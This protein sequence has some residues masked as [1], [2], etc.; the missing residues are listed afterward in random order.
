VADWTMLLD[1]QIAD[2]AGEN[3]SNS[4]GTTI[5]AGA[6]ANTKGSYTQLIASTPFDADWIEV[7]ITWGSVPT[8]GEILVDIAVGAAGSEQDMISNLQYCD[9]SAYSFSRYLFP[10][11]VSAG[12]RIAARS[13]CNTGSATIHVKVNL[14][15]SG[16]IS[17][18][19]LSRVT[20]YGANTS[21]SG[22]TSIDPGGVANTKG[23]YTEIAAATSDPIRGLF[24][25]IGIQANTARTAGTWLV[26]IAVGAAGSEQI[27]IPNLGLVAS[28]DTDLIMPST[29]GILP[30]S[31]PAGTRVA[32]RAQSTITDAADRLFDLIIYGVS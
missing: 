23:A 16:F 11:R 28:G 18:F 13:Q 30:C 1:G 22:G 17:P 4:R 26:D 8:G 31:I 9:S 24:L 19:P 25:A 3:T 10:I 15:G 20:T 32:V 2:T 27:I 14:M 29:I 5:T 6:T 12:T 21:D 7:E